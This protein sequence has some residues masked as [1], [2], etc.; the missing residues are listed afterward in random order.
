MECV[1]LLYMFEV[2]ITTKWPILIPFLFNGNLVFANF[3]VNT[4]SLLIM[5]ALLLHFNQE[6]HESGVMNAKK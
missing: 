1:F 3:A 2:I 6:L 4:H 5:T